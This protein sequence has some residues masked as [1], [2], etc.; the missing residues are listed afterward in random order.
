MGGACSYG[1]VNGLPTCA[2]GEMNARFSRWAGG[3]GGGG[4]GDEDGDAASFMMSDCDA[5]AGI[6]T[7]HHFTS[8]PEATCAAAMS[9]GCDYDC[10]DFYTQHMPAAIAAGLVNRSQLVAST[11]RIVA[12]AFRNGDFEPAA[13][14]PARGIP[15]SVVGSPAHIALAR[16]TAEQAI[17]LLNSEA[18]AVPP[19]TRSPAGEG[20]A[21]AAA[22]AAGGSAAVALLPLV[23]GVG[24]SIAFIGPHANSSE[25]LLSNYFGR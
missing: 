1:S 7:Q 15:A 2:N 19:P 16:S 10:G 25:L 13:A 6:L 14:E 20:G 12:A 9:G 18:A 21:A 11:T 3:G 22:T 23:P 17:T 8:T 4:G 24:G 5:V